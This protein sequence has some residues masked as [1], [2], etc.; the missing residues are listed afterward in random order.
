MKSSAM[1]RVEKKYKLYEDRDEITEDTTV[2]PGCDY[3]QWLI[4][5]RQRNYKSSFHVIMRFYFVRNL[6]VYF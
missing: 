5:E 4:T 3:N 1:T 6:I 2:F